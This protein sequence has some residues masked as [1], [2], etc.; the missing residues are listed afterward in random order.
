[1]FRYIPATTIIQKM[2][3]LKDIDPETLQQSRALLDMFRVKYHVCNIDNLYILSQLNHLRSGNEYFGLVK[4]RPSVEKLFKNLKARTQMCDQ[5]GVDC[6]PAYNLEPVS[7]VNFVRPINPSFDYYDPN[8]LYNFNEK[9]DVQNMH[10][11]NPFLREKSRQLSKLLGEPNNQGHIYC[12]VC[13]ATKDADVLVP[14]MNGIDV[15]EINITCP[16]GA[17]YEVCCDECE[18]WRKTVSPWVLPFFVCEN[19]NKACQAKK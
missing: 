15:E 18:A 7:D 4:S 12:Q 5:C 2:P 1:M 10:S 8:F 13:S 6:L 19:V 3:P 17:V 9:L 16:G 11:S 14:R